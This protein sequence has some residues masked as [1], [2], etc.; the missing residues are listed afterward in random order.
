MCTRLSALIIMAS[1]TLGGCAGIL[2]EPAPPP[3]EVDF[4]PATETAA[5]EP[6]PAAVTLGRMQ[7]P[8]WLQG[9][10]IHYRDAASAPNLLERYARHVWAAPPAELLAEQIEAMLQAR[11]PRPN[12]APARLELRLNRFE[13]VLTE[14]GQAHADARLTARLH[15]PDGALREEASF[16]ARVDVTA[17]ING[18]IDGLP[19]AARRLNRDLGEWLQRHL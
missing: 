6:L 13:H 7:A 17:D 8:S 10:A 11:A 16:R 19:A 15:D 18:A 12:G 4:G 1:L 14:D 2:P 3:A 9:T 5:A